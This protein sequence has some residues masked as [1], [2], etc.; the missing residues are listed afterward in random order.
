[1][2]AQ[3]TMRI[4]GPVTKQTTEAEAKVIEAD[5]SFLRSIEE[6][7]LKAVEGAKRKKADLDIADQSKS[8]AV[9]KAIR[10]K[11]D[12]QV[13]KYLIS[14]GAYVEFMD[15]DGARP[16]MIAIRADNVAAVELLVDLKD[17]KGQR[18][19]DLKQTVTSSGN[20]LLHEA[21]WY[22][23]TDCARILLE[24]GEFNK[25]DDLAKVNQAGQTVMHLASFQA[26][27]PFL[28]LLV[29]YGGD[30]NA[31]CSSGGRYV[32]QTPTQLASTMGKKENAKC[33]GELQ[34]AINSIRFA[35]RMKAR[36]LG[37]AKGVRD[38]TPALALDKKTPVLHMKLDY[39]LKLFTAD[40]E[41]SFLVKLAQQATLPPEELQV[42]SKTAGSVILEIAL[43][44]P[45]ANAGLEKIRTKSLEELSEALGYK[46]V[47]RFV[48]P[49]GAKPSPRSTP[50]YAASPRGGSSRPS[51]RSKSHE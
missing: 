27:P 40:L 13:L 19:V 48:A 42:L 24:T 5:E 15:R 36:R 39:D 26:A 30:V 1:M 22:D 2:P 31:P 46:V 21:A 4:V 50:D 14:S 34:M 29:A 38:P 47:A 37:N 33:I 32:A 45:N 11:D 6:G 23:R 7:N 49:P 9:H 51:G 44:G 12:N 20:S 18:V 28:Q 10:A 3:P 25:D 43:N 16:I 8:G 17:A 35:T 41:K